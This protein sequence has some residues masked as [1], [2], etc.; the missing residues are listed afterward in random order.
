LVIAALLISCHHPAK[1]APPL[2]IH[3]QE[4]LPDELIQSEER[5][6][7]STAKFIASLNTIQV[8]AVIRELRVWDRG[9]KITVA[10]NGGTADLR[11]QIAEAAHVWSDV[12][13]VVFDFGESPSN[14]TYREW[15]PSDEKYQ[16]DVRIA[17]G[18]QPQGGYWSAVGKESIDPGKRP[19]RKPSMNFE[20]FTE[21]LPGDWKSI[22][23]HEFG[24]V[25][26]FEHEHQGPLS[27]C[28]REYRW[29]DDPGYIPTKDPKT[30]QFIPDPQGRNPGI[31][32]GLRGAPNRWT[33]TQIE[34]NLK[35]FPYDENLKSSPFDKDSI[36]KY[37][38]DDWMYKNLQ[39]SKVSGCYGPKNLVLSAEDIKAASERY[40][41]DSVSAKRLTNDRLSTLSKLL[42][43]QELP[44]ELRSTFTANKKSL[45][46]TKPRR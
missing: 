43:R 31:Y 6:Q 30:D 15:S 17:F 29:D 46:A 25:L 27:T 9:Q 5:F 35:K 38:F 21:H 26:G 20:G 10:F 37:H 4:G 7:G 41:K 12:A 18:L 32:T 3:I 39:A 2:Q 14:G 33:D 23:V 24:H 28:E 45:L 44:A 11:R 34:F 8:Q 42:A 19:P 40:P 16:A 36:M 22:V 13:D 1:T